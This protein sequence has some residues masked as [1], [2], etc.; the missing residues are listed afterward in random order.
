MCSGTDEH[1]SLAIGTYTRKCFLTL[2]TP[3]TYLGTGADVFNCH[4]RTSLYPLHC[5]LLFC[6]NL[7]LF[8]FE[9]LLS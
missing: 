8:H 7:L 1:V 4:V 3:A 2:G 5:L 9:N 6:R